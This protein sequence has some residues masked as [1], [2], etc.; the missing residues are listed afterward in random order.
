MA[1]AETS[2]AARLW[3][4]Y[5]SDKWWSLPLYLVVLFIGFSALMGA[6]EAWDNQLPLLFVPLA[7]VVAGCAILVVPP[8]LAEAIGYLVIAV[9]VV[10]SPLALLPWTQS[11][12]RRHVGSLLD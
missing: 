8:A 10:S 11:W 6:S 3:G 9:V 4:W 1:K 2:W 7:L 12:W 5:S